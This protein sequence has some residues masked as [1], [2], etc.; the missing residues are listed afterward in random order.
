MD[1]KI[2]FHQNELIFKFHFLI[3]FLKKIHGRK[4]LPFYSLVMKLVSYAL[5]ILISLFKSKLLHILFFSSKDFLTCVDA[6]SN[7]PRQLEI[8]FN[9]Q[10]CCT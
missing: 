9:P 10:V 3:K 4:I 8:T 6:H 2:F 1:V 7:L 5:C